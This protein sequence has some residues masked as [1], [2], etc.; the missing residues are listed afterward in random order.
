MYLSKALP[1]FYLLL[2]CLLGSKP[3]WAQD[4]TSSSQKVDLPKTYKSLDEALQE[5]GQVQV[6]DL[7]GQ[8]LIELPPSLVQLKN[9]KKLYL[10]SN[11]LSKL[12]SFLSDLG[13]LE[14]ID[15][16]DNQLSDL[17][18]ELAQL[19][20]KYLDLGENRFRE[21]PSV[22]W[23]ISSLEHLY[24]YGN[25]LRGLPPDIARLKNLKTL[26]LGSGL[27]IF[28]Q[29][30]RIRHLPAAI[31]QLTQLEELYLPDN[32]I[33]SLPD[34]IAQASQLRWL[35]LSHTRFQKLPASLSSLPNLEYLSIW[36]RSYTAPQRANLEK[37]YPKARINWIPDY[38]GSYWGLFAGVQQGKNTYL[39]LGLSRNFKKDIVNLA[40][41]LSGEVNLQENR[42]GAKISAWVNG[43]T[44]FSLGLHGVYY[45]GEGPSNYGIR[46]EIGWGYGVFSLTYGYNVFFQKD[47]GLDNRHMVNFR[48][49]L[50]FAPYFN[51][52]R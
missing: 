29:G 5:A 47:A 22:L 19:P 34:S 27:R 45:G 2:I 11:K 51:I 16:Y 3:T 48:F 9:L 50:P 7:G 32:P 12:P 30:N 6:L 39:E 42:Q 13:Q 40:V 24:L 1:F 20:L 8:D 17:P 35:D 41:G 28:G 31:G 15:L 52:F 33:R 4:T 44:L 37:E 10:Y 38:E 14:F 26:R 46:P 21:I 23:E 25:R 18:P 49:I 43:L 36:N